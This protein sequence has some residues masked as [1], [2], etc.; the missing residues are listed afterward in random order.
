[1]CDKCDIQKAWCC[2]GTCF[3]QETHETNEPCWGEVEVVDEEYNG[4]DYWWI[5][6][7]EGHVGCW[8]SG[9]YKEKP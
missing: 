9:H 4:D 2:G 6:A 7:C 1:M 3:A 5:H 8:N